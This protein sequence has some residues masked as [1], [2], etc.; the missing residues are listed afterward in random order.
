MQSVEDRFN[1]TV[2]LAWKLGTGRVGQ[3]GQLLGG[4]AKLDLG[5]T[6]LLVAV[7]WVVVVMLAIMLAEQ[8]LV[9]RVLRHGGSRVS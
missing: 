7:E 1:T 6:S 2:E 5:D 4:V 8:R 3:R 9:R